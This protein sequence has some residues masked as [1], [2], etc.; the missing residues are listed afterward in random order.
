MTR[1]KG[2][3]ILAL[4]LIAALLLALPMPTV[5]ADSYSIVANGK[6]VV[7]STDDITHAEVISY[8]STLDCNNT[9]VGS[10]GHVCCFYYA[11]LM[12]KKIWGTTDG[13]DLLKYVP[14]ADRKLNA[15]N[16]Q[17]YLSQATP[18]S[19]F[20]VGKNADGSG[21]QAHSMIFLASSSSGATFWEGNYDG[22]GR[23]RIKTFTWSDLASYLGNNTYIVF[24]KSP[25]TSPIL[26]EEPTITGEAKPTGTLT[27][28]K[29]FSVK[30]TI[31]CKYTLTEINAQIVDRQTNAVICNKSV[32]P[33]KTSYTIGTT[34]E[35][36]NTAM[37]FA[38]LNDGYY[39]YR[40][41]ASYNK[42]GTVVQ[43][44]L[45]Y[46]EFITGNPAPLPPEEP[47]VS[48]VSAPSGTLI[49]GNGY[50][51]RATITSTTTITAVTARV[52]DRISGATMF[53]VTVNPNTTT[54]SFDINSTI[55]KAMQ[56]R[57]LDDGYYRYELI[58]ENGNTY[59]VIS[60]DFITGNPQPANVGVTEIKVYWD[61]LYLNDGS[62]AASD[63]LIGQPV[64]FTVEVSPSNATNQTV[65]WSSSDPSIATITSNG[66][67]FFSKP[68]EVMITCLA[69]DGSNVSSTFSIMTQHANI[70][71]DNAVAPTCTETGLTVG[72]HC[73]SCGMV[74]VAQQIVP[75]LGHA[76]VVD[77]AVAATCTTTGLTQGKH[78]SRCNTVLI[79]QEITPAPGH[80]NCSWKVVREA[81]TTQDGLEQYECGVCHAVLDSRAIPKVVEAEYSAQ[82]A[83][84]AS[85]MDADG[86][87]TVT[88]SLKNNPGIAWLTLSSD[89]ATKGITLVKA[90]AIGSAAGANVTTGSKIVVASTSNISG[91][92]GILLI[93]FKANNPEDT[94]LTFAC[95]E[96]YT[97]D[98]EPVNVSSVNIEVKKIT[99]IP[100]DATDDGVVDG[101]DV[102]RLMKYFAGQGVTFNALNSDVTGDNTVDGRDVLRLM[103]YFAGQT[104]ELK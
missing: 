30:G 38:S 6:T 43:K 66:V 53:T 12:L 92:S 79:A 7:V 72:S 98:E 56:F 15:T 42:N 54:Y 71:T 37:T 17:K 51:V 85:N 95:D 76:E 26:P 62:G 52:T 68:G 35:A 78:C 22:T 8:H 104:V 64:Q 47:T 31:G 102:L 9:A 101:R 49:K 4:M 48:N 67:L 88:L 24:I 91:E 70:V 69:E 2:L 86:N 50:G 41:V 99:R 39:Y 89:F 73:A 19:H 40:L 21:Y 33:N 25:A 3:R 83:A 59:T 23:V 96:C 32:Y 61:G 60:S 81:T 100:G 10:K 36:I 1:T 20:R 44:E 58:V 14:A 97:L 80:Q 103:K 16:L 84:T 93:T 57:A 11:V 13:T 27:K 34:S 55:D 75:A 82:L 46:S 94:T 5:L 63:C 87:F 45:V 74:L 29:T 28:G 90:E 77:K 65:S 18:G